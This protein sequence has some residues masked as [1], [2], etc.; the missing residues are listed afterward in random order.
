M[1]ITKSL[2][3]KI[4]NY[5]SQKSLGSQFRSRRIA[6]LLRLIE[7]VSSAH[8]C[9][10]IID[11]GGTEK[12]WGIVQQQ[13]LEKHNVKI[14]IVNLPASKLPPDSDF[15]T[16]IHADGCELAE[17]EDRSFHIAHSNSVIEHV[18]DWRRMVEFSKE[19]K[20]VAQ[21]YF[22]QTP[23]Y[24]FPIEPHCMTPFIHWLP[25]PMRLW[26]IMKFSLGHWRKA[27]SVDEAVRLVESARL[28]N[29]KM[30]CE[31]FDDSELF[32]ERLLFMPKSF[33]GVR[34]EFGHEQG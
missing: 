26:L 6:P 31:L 3:K 34:S 7:Q 33:I 21:Y 8:G 32:I 11:V 16:F 2:A 19:L 22:I 24:W 28:L 18:G 29:K 25:K 12:Y 15:F 10:N 20:R 30:F 5:D 1:S 9:V 4:T 14:T 23:N 27:T 17:F 13:Y